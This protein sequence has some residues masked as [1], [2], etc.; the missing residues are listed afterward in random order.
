[1]LWTIK[2]FE[3]STKLGWQS[4][5]WCVR[6][7]AH[8]GRLSVSFV[9]AQRNGWELLCSHLKRTKENQ[10]DMSQSGFC[11]WRHIHW[12]E[13]WICF[14]LHLLNCSMTSAVLDVWPAGRDAA[15][16]F[17][18]RRPQDEAGG[19]HG[20]GLRERDHDPDALPPERDH[21]LHLQTGTAGPACSVLG[22]FVW[23]CQLI[24]GSALVRLNLIRMFP[25]SCDSRS[26]WENDLVDSCGWKSLSWASDCSKFSCCFTFNP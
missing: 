11:T 16:A 10:V 3:N 8:L 26:L 12:S 2:V 20:S 25:K 23:L 6:D 19:G 22:C 1:M 13:V 5:P 18:A 24:R 14:V 7:P 9:K 4:R 21:H 17:A 15:G